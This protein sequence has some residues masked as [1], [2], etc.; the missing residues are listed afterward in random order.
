MIVATVALAAATLRAVGR[1]GAGATEGRRQVQQLQGFNA[2]EPPPS[3]T[4]SGIQDRPERRQ[5]HPR[6]RARHFR[7][8]RLLRAA[9]EGHRPRIEG[10][11]GLG[12]RAPENFLEDHSASIRPRRARPPPSSCSTTT[13]ASNRPQHHE[14]L[15]VHPGQRRRLRTCSGMQRRTGRGHAASVEAT[16]KQGGKVVLGGPL[17]G[18]SMTT[19]YATCGTPAGSRCATM[20]FGPRVHRRLEQ[21]DSG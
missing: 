15:P 17:A 14:A 13:S 19:A 1:G 5:E 11:A 2:P 16:K 3:T 10:L 7:Q 21:P 8:R 12:D 4:R 20:D 18:G 9:G 6:P